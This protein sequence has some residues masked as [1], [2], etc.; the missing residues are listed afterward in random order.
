MDHTDDRESR[1]QELPY[2]MGDESV[3]AER[4]L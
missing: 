1:V 4:L 2:C 3:A